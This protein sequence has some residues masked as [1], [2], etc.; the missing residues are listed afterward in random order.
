VSKSYLQNVINYCKQE[1]I[2]VLFEPTSVFKAKKIFGLDPELLHQVKYITPDKH[3]AKMLSE[4]YYEK[5]FKSANNHKQYL[6]PGLEKESDYALTLLNMFENVIVKCGSSGCLVATNHSKWKIT[7]VQPKIVEKIE[8]VTGAG[9][10]LVG[11]VI[12]GLS[13]SG[14]NPSHEELVKLVTAGVRGA[15]LSIQSPF[16]TSPQLHPL[17]LPFSRQS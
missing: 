8:S 1:N 5:G 11:V 13:L 9:D 3:E 14:T 17:L 10:T 7:H 4:M 6:I 15:E 2:P 16:A 12:G